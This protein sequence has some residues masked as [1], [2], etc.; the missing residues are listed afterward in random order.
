MSYNQKQ[1]IRRSPI[2]QLLNRA[3]LGLGVV[4][5]TAGAIKSCGDKQQEDMHNKIIELI[6]A[7]IIK[8]NPFNIEI[9]QDVP[10]DKKI[11]ILKD[12]MLEGKQYSDEEQKLLVNL[13]YGL[14][15]IE[16]DS[17]VY[18]GTEAEKIKLANFVSNLKA[19]ETGQDV[20]LGVDTMGVSV[21][22]CDNIQG[23]YGVYFD[24]KLLLSKDLDEKDVGGFSTIAHEMRH[25]NQDALGVLEGD[26]NGCSLNERLFLTK[27]FEAD[28]CA[29]SAQV[30]WEMKQKNID[31]G[32]DK[33]KT[34]KGYGKIFVDYENSA[35]ENPENTKNGVA[36]RSAFEAWFDND[37]LQAAYESQV[38]Y[39]TFYRSVMSE[40]A[41][42]D[43]GNNTNNQ[44]EITKI[45]GKVGQLKNGSNYLS[46]MTISGNR[47]L[48]SDRGSR[49]W[50]VILK[51]ND[52]YKNTQD[53]I[54]IL[55]SLD[56]SKVTGLL[57]KQEKDSAEVKTKIL[58]NKLKAK[59]R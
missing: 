29:Y 37:K 40:A 51:D 54:S 26:F 34:D 39:T 49:Y 23:A 11:D 24:K 17:L 20:V 38:C 35:K 22:Y 31:V 1:R 6:H 25:G 5:V 13:M 7:E 46:D 42:D 33:L 10:S 58:N 27:L 59:S 19:S 28:A 14:Q 16:A 41:N 50:N 55:C 12:K 47:D 8:N 44:S 53:V 32:W 4:S 43:F 48:V 52:I 36:M 30:L 21:K 18:Q 57:K 3:L 9:W 2:R 56:K 15:E 45:I